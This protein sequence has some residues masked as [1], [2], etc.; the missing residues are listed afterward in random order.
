MGSFYNNLEGNI[1]I[2]IQ[3]FEFQGEFLDVKY[4]KL[5]QAADYEG[6]A[7]GLSRNR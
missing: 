1:Q 5:N 6:S 7:G 2:Q 3:Q 4:L